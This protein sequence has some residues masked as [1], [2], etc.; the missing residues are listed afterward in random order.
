M[1]HSNRLCHNDQQS[2]H[3]VLLF[4]INRTESLGDV[5]KERVMLLMNTI[6]DYYAIFYSNKMQPRKTSKRAKPA[7]KRYDGSDDE[8]S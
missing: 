8:S 4:K 3:T 6:F 2:S 1:V 5:S 7:S